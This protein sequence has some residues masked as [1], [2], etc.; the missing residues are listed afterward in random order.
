MKKEKYNFKIIKKIGY[1]PALGSN[2]DFN[3]SGYYL[4]DNKNYYYHSGSSN[5]SY[6]NLGDNLDQIIKRYR[7]VLI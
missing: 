6:G 2:K 1:N 4:A 5:S 3:Q 7:I